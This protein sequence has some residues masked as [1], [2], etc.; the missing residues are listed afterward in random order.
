MKSMTGFA[1]G[2]F[3]VN[4]KTVFV[5]F[6]SFNNRYLEISLRGT[7]MTPEAERL[8]REMVKNRIHRGKVEIVCDVFENNP[9]QWSIQLNDLLL[10]DILEKLQQFKK[11]YKENV[12]LSLDPLLKL[13]M[14][15]HLDPSSDPWNGDDAAELRAGVERVLESFLS[16]RRQEGGAIATD[17]LASLD[18]IDHH[19]AA[20]RDLE[21][22]VEEEAFAT[23]RKKI[24]KILGGIAVD[25]KRIA[26]EAALAAEKSSIAEEINRLSTH[27]RRLRGLIVASDPD[28]QG[29]EA[30]FLTQ[31]MQRETHTIAAKTSSLGI[32]ESILHTRREIDKIRQQV[33]NIE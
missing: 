8:L 21:K 15:F 11:K 12:S 18:Q 20:I 10:V 24:E 28:T 2:R 4:T 17:L 27:A 19:L 32:H 23:F 6:K 25:E 3:S 22:Q 5:Q 31:E 26:Q 16:A 9:A 30:D 29:R 33:Q 7:G 14:I 13:P 1:Q